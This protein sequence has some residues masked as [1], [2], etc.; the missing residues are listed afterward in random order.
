MKLVRR[1]VIATLKHNILFK[2]CH[3]PGLSNNLADS[4]SRLQV[5]QFLQE[6]PFHHP[7]QM[8]VPPSS[9]TL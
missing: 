9:V 2:A 6:C 7:L 5:E 8:A 4:L 1:L 3:I